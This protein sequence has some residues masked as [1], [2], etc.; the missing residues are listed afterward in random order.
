MKSRYASAAVVILAAGLIFWAPLALAASSATSTA[1]TAGT[2]VWNGLEQIE[3]ANS[4]FSSAFL[5]AQMKQLSD[6]SAQSLAIP[7]LFGVSRLDLIPNFGEAR[8]TSRA[9]EGL[10]IPVLKG[11]PIVTPTEAVVLSAGSGVSSG[12]TVST[13][14]PGGETFVYMHLDRIAMLKAGDR[15]EPGDLIGFAGNTGNA[16]GGAAHLHFEIRRN[17]AT[18]PYPRLTGEFSASQKMAFAA[19]ILDQSGD[20][21]AL[22]KFF[23]TNYPDAFRTAQAS[24]ITIPAAVA[25][26]LPQTA[27]ATPVLT[28]DVLA[29]GSKGAR[30]SAL[31]A[32]LIA[33]NKGTAAAALGYAGATGYFGALTRAALIEY[34]V[35]TGIVPASG[36]YAI[37][38]GSGNDFLAGLK[39]AAAPAL[40]D[41]TAASFT[42]IA[43]LKT[44]ILKL[45]VQILSLQIQL[46]KLKSGA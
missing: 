25:A 42:D 17:G 32:F 8:G 24:G 3:I 16:A 10:D 12:N 7:V 41:S 23:A 21:T 28:D 45:Q 4:P 1:E 2:P 39:S 35:K 36:V 14:N 44:M 19:A 46:L 26:Q 33:Q 9:H 13:A 38:P 43:D 34:Q 18:D 27:T 11:A 5:K 6:V 15:L 20:E 40:A 22:A 29:A 37:A 30:V 31:Q